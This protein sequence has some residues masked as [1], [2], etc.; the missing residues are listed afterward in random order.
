MA[1]YQTLRRIAI[2]IAGLTVLAVG[3]A[4]LVLPGPGLVVVAVGLGILS[5]EYAWARHWL[6]K[7]KDTGSDMVGK[8][9]NGTMTTAAQNTSGPAEKCDGTSAAGDHDGEETTSGRPA[10]VSP[11]HAA[12]RR[13]EST[14]SLSHRE[15]H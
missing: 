3:V 4:L 15:P 11:A 9:K 8:L 7:M 12:N 6:K 1:T 14:G 10:D 5:L 13:R 2:S